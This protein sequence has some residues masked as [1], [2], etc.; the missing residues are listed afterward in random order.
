MTATQYVEANLKTE[1]SEFYRK[2]IEAGFT[3]KE[4]RAA[5]LARAVRIN[6]RDNGNTIAIR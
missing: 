4:L 1:M 3:V 5:V 2:G 6:V